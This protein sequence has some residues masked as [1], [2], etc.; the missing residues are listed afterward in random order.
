M[1]FDQLIAEM[2]A[3]FKSSQ[4]VS[5]QIDKIQSEGLPYLYQQPLVAIKDKAQREKAIKSVLDAVFGDSGTAEHIDTKKELQQELEKAV[6]SVSANPQ[7]GFLKPIKGIR[8]NYL[9]RWLG[10]NLE[11]EYTS[12]GAKISKQALKKLAQELSPAPTTTKQVPEPSD[13]TKQEA[14]SVKDENLNEERELIESAYEV[15][16]KKFEKLNKRAKRY[17]LPIV[18]IEKI[19]ERFAQVDNEFDR[20][21]R[22][23]K[24]IT[25]RLDVPPFVLPGGWKFIA[26]VDHLGE[27]NVVVKVPS[28]A[29]QNI[30]LFDQ[31]GKA[32]SSYCV[33][34]KKTRNRT[35][36]F[37]VQNDEGKLLRV[38]RQ[39]LKDY[40]PGG[41]DAAKK[42]L[43]YAEYLNLLYLGIIDVE[44]SGNG[45]EDF[46]GGG[47]NSRTYFD[48]P[49]VLGGAYYLIKT[50]GFVKRTRDPE[51]A[52]TIKMPTAD[53]L[54][55]L[56]DGSLQKSKKEHD[57]ALW[58]GFIN[59]EEQF[60]AKA[61]DIIEWAGPYIRQQIEQTQGQSI[62][63]Y[64][65]NLKVI[66]GEDPANNYTSQKYFGFLASLVD[67]YFKAQERE[68]V[69]KL[70]GPGDLKESNYVGTPGLPIGELS[71]TQKRKVKAAGID[72]NAFPYNGPIE[73]TLDVYRTISRQV[74]SYYDSG[75]SYLVSG[76]DAEG[77]VYS[78]FLN[79]DWNLEAGMK[80]E[81]TNATV[82]QHK[83]VSLESGRTIK[84]T[85][86]TRVKFNVVEDSSVPQENQPF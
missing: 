51:E 55:R 2:A 58:E 30:D 19:G 63:D 78:T 8:A 3:T 41:A 75:V 37:I 60:K 4:S 68:A 6:Q 81:I 32:K 43:S 57:V 38:G 61:S 24:L 13:P 48:F 10:T 70:K 9:G 79:E 80:I 73:I 12:S 82:K 64:F 62:N 54:R 65:R 23:V 84:Q 40:I 42:M 22:T 66:L 16:V 85:Q 45:G 26:R 5:D 53:D 47:D 1:L 86:L 25:F 83:E 74:F 29:A 72:V 71:A 35:S 34:C 31:Y 17:G 11:V 28:E 52:D 56:L 44:R 27:E 15:L 69:E 18:S 7:S 50:L 14:V 39:C 33:H 59:N 20:S 77:N 21:K 76:K 36:T 46:G 49:S 67:Q